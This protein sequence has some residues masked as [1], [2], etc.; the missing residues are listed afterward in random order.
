MLHTAAPPKLHVPI[1]FFHK[2][3]VSKAGI[4]KLHCIQHFWSVSFKE[5]LALRIAIGLHRQCY[6]PKLNAVV[7][8][9]I[10]SYRKTNQVG[11]YGIAVFPMGNSFVAGECFL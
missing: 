5:R 3:I 6:C 7:K 1:F 8:N 9:G 11:G 2:R 10:V 4:K